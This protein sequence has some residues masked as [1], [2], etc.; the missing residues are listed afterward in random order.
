MEETR[1]K[2]KKFRENMG[3]SR[4]TPLKPLPDLPGPKLEP[5][6]HDLSSHQAELLAFAG[7]NIFRLVDGRV[8]KV[9]IDGKLYALKVVSASRAECPI[10]SRGL[11]PGVSQPRDCM[12]Y[13][14]RFPLVIGHIFPI[15]SLSR[16]PLLCA[17]CPFRFKYGM[18]MTL[19]LPVPAAVPR[20]VPY[21]ILRSTMT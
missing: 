13:V 7:P 1:Q 6:T 17:V 16:A 10:S 8:L 14:I 11:G 19:S 15:Q 2:S 3:S 12:P 5:F 20:I 4:K 18:L 9:R 21:N